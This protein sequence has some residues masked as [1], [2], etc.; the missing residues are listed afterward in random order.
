MKIEKGNYFEFVYQ[1][2]Q[3]IPRGKVTTYGAIAAY[4][5]IKSGGRMVGYAMSSVHGI[6]DLPAHR[7]VNRQGVLTGKHHFGH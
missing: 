5:G 4:L 1:V 7:V 2:V 6:P 3:L